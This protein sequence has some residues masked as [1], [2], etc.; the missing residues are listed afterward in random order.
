MDPLPPSPVL[1][2]DGRKSP[3]G[4]LPVNDRARWELISPGVVVQ[5]AGREHIDLVTAL[6]QAVSR[7]ADH[8]FGSSD[9]GVAVAR[10]DEGY[11][12]PGALLINHA[13]WF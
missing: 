6:G 5:G 12:P 7:L 3:D 10:G 9:D 1:C 11:A 8:G 13:E 4:H 2:L